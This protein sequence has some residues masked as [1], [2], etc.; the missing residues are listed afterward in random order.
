MMQ[1]EIVPA[2]PYPI[3]QQQKIDFATKLLDRFRNPYIDHKWL[4]ISLQYT[5]KMKM[6][7][8][9]LLLQYFKLFDKVP[10]C[11]ATAFAAYL[12][13]MKAVDHKEGK[14]FGQIRGEA[15]EIR[16]DAASFFYD[17]WKNND[18]DRLVERVL[19]QT[20]LWGSDLTALPG[21]AHTVSEQLNKIIAHG[22]YAV[23]RSV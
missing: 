23:I 20:S 7:N 5:S 9:P 3:D 10:P 19:S 11:M 1:E 22:A 12:Y 17:S 18:P 13:F 8:V 16:D 6:R 14:Y 21:F 15:Y 2:I 4:S